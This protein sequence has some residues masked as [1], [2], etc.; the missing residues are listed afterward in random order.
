MTSVLTRG[1]ICILL[2]LPV[3]AIGQNWHPF[4][5]GKHY[6][7]SQLDEGQRILESIAVETSSYQDSNTLFLHAIMCE[8]WDTAVALGFYGMNQYGYYSQIVNYDKPAI[9]TRQGDRII[10]SDFDKDNEN[11]WNFE[12]RP[13]IHEGDTWETNGLEFKCTSES[14]GLV[15]NL[16]DSIKIIRCLTAPFDTVEFVLTKSHGFLQYFPLR[17]FHESG[18]ERQRPYFELWGTRDLQGK[19]GYQQPQFD[20]YFHLNVNDVLIWRNKVVSYLSYTE[21]YVDTILEVINTAE[22]IAYRTTRRVY[23]EE[24]IFRR[25]GASELSYSKG[26]EGAILEGPI[27]W[28]DD[29]AGDFYSLY[30]LVVRIEGGDTNVIAGFWNTALDIHEVSCEFTQWTDINDTWSFSTKRGMTGFYS[31]D[32]GGS[33]SFS[34]FGSVINDVR[35]GF[36]DIPT[37]VFSPVVHELFMF[38]NPTNSV[39]YFTNEDVTLESIEV[40]DIQGRQH[41]AKRLDASTLD[42]V[43]LPTGVYF[44]RATDKNGVVYIGTV[45]KE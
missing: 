26:F 34:L 35:E 41:I 9:A 15:F 42:L 44:L 33:K 12:F 38:P 11:W 20:D 5:E 29:A 18:L 22:G 14:T 31:N 10:I 16:L 7:W 8:M 40:I 19:L 32:F 1:I 17:N 3:A 21:Y 45:V 25:K 4:V 13:F 43:S 37:S 36:T 27:S 2:V 23:D 28:I 24:W 30:P 6:T 39:V